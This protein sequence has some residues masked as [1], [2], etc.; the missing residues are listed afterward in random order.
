MACRQ[1]VRSS[2]YPRCHSVNEQRLRW[3]GC[4]LPANHTGSV[5]EINKRK[6]ATLE[7]NSGRNV[8]WNVLNNKPAADKPYRRRHSEA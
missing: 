6:R 1:V 5:S 7:L 3:R 2:R 8:K 4:C